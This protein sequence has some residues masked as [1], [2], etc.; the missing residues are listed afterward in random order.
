MV[1]PRIHEVADS[2]YSDGYDDHASRLFSLLVDV[3]TAYRVEIDDNGDPA[4]SVT[5]AGLIENL[6][7]TRTFPA[8]QIPRSG[9]GSATCND[10]CRVKDV[11]R[12][13]EHN[14]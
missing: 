11:D 7:D 3:A 9:W 14:T 2:L 10:D 6:E 1:N 5:I 13:G 4:S 12:E 8:L